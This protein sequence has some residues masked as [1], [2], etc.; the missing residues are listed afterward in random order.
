MQEK[1]K[2]G[3]C[4]VRDILVRELSVPKNTGL[5]LRP[6]FLCDNGSVAE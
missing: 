5:A 1:L 2:P 4:L 6:L 3:R